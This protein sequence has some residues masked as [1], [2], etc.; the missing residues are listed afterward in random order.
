MVNAM[1]EIRGLS[2][3]F[4]G[5]LATDGVDLTVDRG[6]IHALIGPN[7]AGKTTLIGQLAGELKPDAGEIRLD[8]ER[9]DA[10]PVAR[11]VAL[12]LARTFQITSLLPEFS[13]LQSVELAFQIKRGHSFR[14]WRQ[15][16]ID[17]GRRRR[18]QDV[19]A[20]TGLGAV[21]E[22]P[23]AALSHG[24]RRQ[25][26]LALAL[27]LSP[28]LVLL[29]EPMAG[30]GQAETE[31][32]TALLGGLKGHLTMVLVEH[33]MDAVFALADRISVLVGGALIA[34]GGRDAIRRDA[35]VQAAYLG[36]EAVC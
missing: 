26:E 33:D 25:L 31:R 3:R 11:R 10:L 8:G 20:Q 27:A 7:G 16:G 14:F 18:A 32:M 4:G 24:E 13:P 1:L 29:D 2:K 23:V 22:R 28:K 15:A 6:E 34:T 19:L 36:G 12:G 5:L 9:I 17:A 30:L 21:A 35:G